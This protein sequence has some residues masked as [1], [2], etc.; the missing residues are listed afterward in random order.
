[1]KNQLFNNNNGFF[2][3]ETND[4]IA[5][6]TFK[7]DVLLPFSYLVN[8]TALFSYL[9]LYSNDDSIRVVIITDKRKRS[10]VEEYFEFYKL[11]AESKIDERTLSRM[12]RAYDQL[13]VK[14][15]RSNKFF[16]SVGQGDMISQDFYVDLACDYKIVADNAVIHKP[17][18]ELGLVP[19]GGGAYFLKKKLGHCKAYEILLSRK[20][21][22]AHEALK[23]G[24]VNKVVPYER[25]E[26]TVLKT[27]QRF[28]RKPPASLSRTKRLL[29]YPLKD[30]EDYLAFETNELLGILR[31]SHILC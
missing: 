16:I 24:M 30:L 10:P 23:L 3:V 28:A 9:D 31:R 26:D 6:L 12:Y 5:T 2:T 15:V 7:G 27:A 20:R 25:L 29:N 1:M 18:L 13:I 17:Y 11:L 8:K 19:K 22:S 14:I 4:N 21:I